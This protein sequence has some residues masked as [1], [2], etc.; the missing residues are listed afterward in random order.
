MI[1]TPASLIKRFLASLIDIVILLVQAI[2][3]SFILSNRWNQLVIQ[4][5]LVALYFA[6]FE[7]SSWHATPGKK[8]FALMI[9]K[10]DGQPLCFGRALFRWSC[11][12]IFYPLSIILI[13]AILLGITWFLAYFGGD[14]NKF[15][16]FIELI[17]LTN[18]V[19]LIIFCII[20]VV[21]I[22]TPA[23]LL[24]LPT[25]FTEDKVLLHDWISNTRVVQCSVEK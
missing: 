2:L 6:T 18:P 10:R 7:G 12:I 15:V 9:E 20:L 8:V 17:I 14:V 22:V 4:L 3:L 24:V 5:V 13:G 23:L 16:R 19:C 11:P 25:L 21:V 1:K